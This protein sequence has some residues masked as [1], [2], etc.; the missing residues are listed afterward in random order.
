MPS[1]IAL[2]LLLLNE[3][4]VLQVGIIGEEI[5]ISDSR[6]FSIENEMDGRQGSRKGTHMPMGSSFRQRR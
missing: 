1:R 6:Q 3:L 4:V 5:T 2:L